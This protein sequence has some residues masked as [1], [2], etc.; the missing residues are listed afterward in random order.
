MDNSEIAPEKKEP[1]TQIPFGSI[2]FGDFKR[3]AP[4][5]RDFGYERGTPIDRYYIK[6]FLARNAADVRGRVL[7]LATNDY[8]VRFGGERVVRS[9]ILNLEPTK[10]ATI[11]GDLAQAGTL[12]NDAFDCIIFTQ[13]LQYIYDSRAAVETLHRALTPGGVLLATVPA[14]SG[15]DVWPWY[16]TFTAPAIERLLEDRFGRNS[17]T[18]ESHG[19]IFAA[20]AYLYG[21]AFEELNVSDLDVNDS[22]FAVTIAAR[23]TKRDVV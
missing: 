14:I 8:T 1:R 5:G 9:D 20:T 6:A 11:V 7:E 23:A 4:I 22:K 18:T 15:V 21:L 19:N 13:A 16:W 10:T 2:R 12:P 3:H 17:V